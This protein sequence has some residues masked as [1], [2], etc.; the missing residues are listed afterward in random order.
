MQEQ[1]LRLKL[2]KIETLFAGAGTQGERAAAE[3]AIQRIKE[4]LNK[5][6]K[7][8]PPI[9]VKF[10]LGDLWSRQLFLALCRRYELVPYRYARQRHTTVMIKGPQDFIDDILWPEFQALSK[11]L[12]E[13]LAHATEKIIREEIHKDTT[14]A[15]EVVELLESS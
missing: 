5:A 1:E 10:S 15:R 13:Y 6:V 2:R 7:S 11:E 9:E 12:S 8:S 4:K 14:E 3:A